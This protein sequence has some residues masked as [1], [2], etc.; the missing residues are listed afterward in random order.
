MGII[1]NIFSSFFFEH[2]NFT[3]YFPTSFWVIFEIKLGFFSPTLL[4]WAVHFFSSLH[5]KNAVLHHLKF[6]RNFYP[7]NICPIHAVQPMKT[8]VRVFFLQVEIPGSL[9]GGL[10]VTGDFFEMHRVPDTNL[11]LIVK[12]TQRSSQRSCYCLPSEVND[13]LA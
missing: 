4:N 11:F 9:N 8:I 2:V 10:T 1:S 3:L 5:D 12:D 13:V 6:L 7:K